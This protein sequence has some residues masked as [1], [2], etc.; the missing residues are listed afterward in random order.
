M[1][2]P[3]AN[4]WGE[5]SKP[6]S[7]AT[8]SNSW[9]SPSVSV[10]HGDREDDLA[11][12]SWSFEP[13]MAWKHEDSD[14]L[15]TSVWSNKDTN[16]TPWNPLP[17]ASHH[18][19]ISTKLSEATQ[20][21][22]EPGSR[23]TT[24]TGSVEIEEQPPPT[25]PPVD[26]PEPPPIVTPLARPLSI[27]VTDDVDGFG[28]FETADESVG[29]PESATWSPEPPTVS[30][31]SADSTSWGGAWADVPSSP[32][33]HQHEEEG[34]DEWEAARRQ[35][36]RLDRHVP[37]ELLASILQQLESLADELWP[38]PEG[39]DTSD[40]A[41]NFQSE[42]LGL[43]VAFQRL[44]PA[45][46]SLPLPTPFNK[47]FISRQLSE[48]LK[49]TRHTPLTRRGPMAMY[50]LSKG[51]T[52]WEASIKA[53]PIV[54]Q[55]DTAPVGWKIVDNT[56]EVPVTVDPKKKAS[57]GLLSF[58]GRRG[59]T[60]S[61]EASTVSQRS[62]SPISIKGASSPRQSTDNTRPGT[63]QGNHKRSSSISSNK[64]VASQPSAAS[65]NPTEPT[66]YASA[67]ITS[68]GLDEATSAPAPAPSAVSR[69][70]GRFTS[71]SSRRNS[72]DSIA[73]SA[74][75]LEF[76]SDVPTANDEDKG[77]ELDAL[78]MMIKS[79]PLPTQLPP[80]LPPPPKSNFEP[81]RINITHVT[82]PKTQQDDVFDLFGDFEN[83]SPGPAPPVPPVK[84]IPF[85]LN[86]PSP[87]SPP[88]TTI[89][90]TQKQ[91]ETTWPSFD[92]PAVPAARAPPPA[93]KPIV[94]IMSSSKT[95]QAPA[96][97][98]LPFPKQSQS[99]GLSNSSSRNIPFLPPPPSSSSRSHTP[100]P[101]QVATTSVIKEED[102]DDFADFLS[103]PPP[104]PLAQTQ[105]FGDFARLSG[106]STTKASTISTGGQDLFASFDDAFGVFTSGS[107][108][109]PIPPAK[110][111]SLSSQPT[112]RSV[113][114]SSSPPPVAGSSLTR[115]IS[116][117]ADHS[118][119][120]SL[121]E[122]AAARGNW[123][124]PPSPLPEALNPPPASSSDYTFGMN[125]ISGENNHNAIQ[126][127]V[128]PSNSMPT[129]F[130]S[131]GFGQNR[132]N[133]TLLTPSALNVA[134][135][136]IVPPP[137]N[138][139]LVPAAQVKQPEWISQAPLQ[140]K[141]VSGNTP[142]TQAGGLSAQDLS[143]F[144]GL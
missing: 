136:R 121:L 87:V 116:R 133:E 89:D 111:V 120:L 68:P 38:S 109:A 105:A 35:K 57:G 28:T 19:D 54:S 32:R 17:S 84:S 113:T 141:P 14:E 63:P 76:L 73:L 52:T 123:L 80:P 85:N 25:I 10:I 88:P 81:S 1:E 22:S 24:P 74:D 107:P 119:T 42:Q 118:R 41:R 138:S 69:F 43:D 65:S 124:G 4:A 37:P 70:L 58:F 31:T 51:S 47:T 117:K 72:K 55:E 30:L 114:P 29:D 140:P 95:A 100:L 12:P 126:P 6:P 104:D 103:S 66:S 90:R 53:K 45:D 97:P 11:T 8:N 128:L 39:G 27:S 13:D 36:E 26:P 64:P 99:T 79:P 132:L 98:L 33:N 67:G 48:A 112:S 75:D 83:M 20:A 144:E 59:T 142:S 56:P 46:L 62:A 122:T 78:S 93:K 135:T 92:Y 49:L 102:D 82:K 71:Q 61:V 125:R 5:P 139:F 96:V 21:L 110:P 44:V 2:D 16:E 9:S 106:A 91:P 3:W 40:D 108:P 7:T 23:S 143:F 131:N 50:M 34:D 115:K 137:S 129:V 60:S 77:S 127:T 130:S 15:E 18:D 94:A 134:P 86:Q 101:T